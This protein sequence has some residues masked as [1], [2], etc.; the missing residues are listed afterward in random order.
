TQKSAARA[1][2]PG[3]GN[4]HSARRTPLRM[5]FRRPTQSDGQPGAP[6]TFRPW[7]AGYRGR[8]RGRFDVRDA[9]RGSKRFRVKKWIEDPSRKT[10]G[11]RLF[12]RNVAA[13][14]RTAQRYGARRRRLLRD[15]NRKTRDGRSAKRRP[16]LHGAVESIACAAK[17]GNRRDPERSCKHRRARIKGTPINGHLPAPVTDVFPT[18]RSRVT[19]K[20]HLDAA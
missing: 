14:W 16:K 10:G 18:L 17:N 8:R 19:G 4:V 1:R 6:Q 5:P 12:R 13:H 20:L 9:A 2:R 3:R 15:G 11:W 7:R